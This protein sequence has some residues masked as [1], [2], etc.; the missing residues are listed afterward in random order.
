MA[1]SHRGRSANEE[2]RRALVEALQQSRM[3]AY[4]C[5]RMAFGMAD[6]WAGVFRWLPESSPPHD[7][8]D[9]D[10][11]DIDPD[12]AEVIR[13]KIVKAKDE[14]KRLRWELA[15]KVLT[16]VES[17]GHCDIADPNDDRQRQALADA[18]LEHCAELREA[19]GMDKPSPPDEDSAQELDPEAGILLW[20]ARLA[21]YLESIGKYG[22]VT[23]KRVRD[24]SV[25]PRQLNWTDTGGDPGEK[26]WRL[27]WSPEEETPR[28]WLHLGWAVWWEQVRATFRRVGA[29]S[30]PMWA[31]ASSAVR[32]GT[33]LGSAVRPGTQ[34]G[35]V[36]SEHTEVLNRE[37]QAIGAIDLRAIEA[38]Q[39]RES[40]KALASPAGQKLLEICADIIARQQAAKAPAPY[41]VHLPGKSELRSKLGNIKSRD[42]D[43][44]LTAGQQFSAIGGGVHIRGLFLSTTV[45]AAPNRHAYTVLYWNKDLFDPSGLLVP[46]PDPDHELPN[47]GN[48]NRG[49]SGFATLWVLKHMQEYS[50]DLAENGDAA[51]YT[52]HWQALATAAGLTAATAK[53][54]RAELLKPTESADGETPQ[55]WLIE[56]RKGRY[57]LADDRRHTFLVEQGRRRL[58]QAARG[59]ASS[60]KRGGEPS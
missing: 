32:P 15:G 30:E 40:L 9:P 28:A 2:A 10:S 22:G 17:D 51:I 54:L 13:R 56:T 12:T 34:L 35:I 59:K 52:K 27:W 36:F 20:D 46:L 58:K 55:P 41:E 45:A 21:D 26:L 18:L 48:R 4:F 7:W 53:K 44:I 11:L 24:E 8:S 29:L 14:G 50:R 42:L 6:Q 33:Q 16:R 31:V 49:R 38:I 3:S 5:A 60:R 23:A 47:I 37:G 39:A 1:W 43:A 19:A 25:D 57:R